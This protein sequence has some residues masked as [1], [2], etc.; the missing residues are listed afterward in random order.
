MAS[1][2][3]EGPLVGRTDTLAEVQSDL[4]NVGVG[5]SQY[6]DSPTSIKWIYIGVRCSRCG[7][8]GCFAGWK[9]G[10]DDVAHLFDQ[11]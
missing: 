3:D 10:Q 1:E 11:A 4:C 6:A 8:L 2:E 9:V 5:F 7:I